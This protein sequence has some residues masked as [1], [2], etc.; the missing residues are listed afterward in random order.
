MPTHVWEAE[1]H[2]YGAKGYQEGTRKAEEWVLPTVVATNIPPEDVNTL[3]ERERA[4]I[5]TVPTRDGDGW[6]TVVNRKKY[7]FTDETDAWHWLLN[8]LARKGYG[9][10]GAKET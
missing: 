7:S 3:G 8:H 5:A 6:S 1:K 9:S 2:L 10:R 4:N